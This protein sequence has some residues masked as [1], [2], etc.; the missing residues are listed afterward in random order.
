MLQPLKD[1]SSS[2]FQCV[3]A[4]E[5]EK[6]PRREDEDEEFFRLQIHLGLFIVFLLLRAPLL[7]CRK[8][9]GFLR[10]FTHLRRTLESLTLFVC[11]YS[12]EK[13]SRAEPGGKG[14]RVML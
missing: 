7:L 3:P 9:F 5:P 2:S 13:G 4:G 10:F 14:R 8:S 6:K 1:N 12:L 11:F